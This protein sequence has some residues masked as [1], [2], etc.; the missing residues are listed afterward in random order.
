MCNK[1]GQLGNTLEI[2]FSKYRKL[3]YLSISRFLLANSFQC[4]SVFKSMCIYVNE[5]DKN[6][7]VVSELKFRC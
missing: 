4:C 1:L 3:L 7:M 2:D 5:K 6:V